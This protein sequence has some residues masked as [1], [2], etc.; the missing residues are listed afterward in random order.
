[1]NVINE[2]FPK[3]FTNNFAQ[4][5]KSTAVY[6]KFFVQILMPKNILKKNRNQGFNLKSFVT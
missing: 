4:A 5:F 6:K 3:A 2:L 1:M